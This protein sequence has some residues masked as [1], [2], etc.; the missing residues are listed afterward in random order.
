MKSVKPAPVNEMGVSELMHAAFRGD[1]AR[2]ESC[3]ARGDDPNFEVTIDNNK[4]N[5]LRAAAQG[6]HA[7]VIERLLKCGKLKDEIIDNAFLEAALRKK[8]TAVRVF[9]ENGFNPNKVVQ[10]LHLLGCTILSEDKRIID[11]AWQTIKTAQNL[12]DFSFSFVGEE[13][14]IQTTFLHFLVQAD[15]AMMRQYEEE[16][17]FPFYINIPNSK[18][19]TPL[20]VAI[21]AGADAEMVS[22]ILRVGGDPYLCNNS[23]FNA[24]HVACAAWN[25]EAL[26]GLEAN[27]PQNIDEVLSKGEP[28]INPFFAVFFEQIC[29]NEEELEQYQKVISYL[30]DKGADINQRA[31]DGS[32]ALQNIMDV[33]LEKVLKASQDGEPELWG[34][35]KMAEYLVERGASTADFFSKGSKYEK[36]LGEHEEFKKI[37]E[38]SAREKKVAA[39]K[40]DAEKKKS[41]KVAAAAASAA[42]PASVA[43]KEPQS[44]ILAALADLEEFQLDESARLESLRQTLADCVDELALGEVQ[45]TA[46]SEELGLVAQAQEAR[47]LRQNSR[48]EDL[49]KRE[50]NLAKYEQRLRAKSAELD[51]QQAELIEKQAMLE[52]L[53]AE[54]AREAE[55]RG[56]LRSEPIKSIRELPADL[57][58]LFA[59]LQEKEIAAFITGGMAWR[60]NRHVRPANDIDIKL[61]VPKSSAWTALEVKEFFAPFFPLEES[62]IV[63]YNKGGNFTISVKAWQG[64]LDITIND[65]EMP[66]PLSSTWAASREKMLR[67]NKAGEACYSY[68]EGLRQFLELNKIPPNYNILLLNPQAHKLLLRSCFMI[69]V[70]EAAPAEIQSA[71][72]SISA[73]VNP[74]ELLMKELKIDP[75]LGVEGYKSAQGK[76]KQEIIKTM[77]SHGFDAKEEK[78]FLYHF[79]ALAF[80]FGLEQEAAP[81]SK[82][83]SDRRQAVCAIDAILELCSERQIAQIPFITPNIGAII[84]EGKKLRGDGQGAALNPEAKAFASPQSPS[85]SAELNPEN[86]AARLVVALGAKTA[87]K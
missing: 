37:A 62:D 86:V 3:L 34:I 40:K 15:C 66:P 28:K 59:N 44:Q 51:R 33:I 12:E 65:P 7:G 58:N 43:E 5:A 49:K 80:Y 25:L 73:F 69:V 64:R 48:E 8:Q 17:P 81:E 60:C 82:F 75:T 84:D 36:V 57:Q 76:A 46:R 78:Q 29:Q 45:L 77:K 30:L 11:L 4:F 53:A 79:A 85:A 31:G 32:L 83:L 27:F 42:A 14:E 54:M 2:V 70:G 47:E 72:G 10:G 20:H 56:F 61:I 24:F 22:Y 74:L 9:L 55:A 21:L 50:E 52:R 87:L 38:I 63:I 71:L 68:P 41:R 39:R 16:I 35:Y 18:G 23:G 1:L 6:G 26:Q 67:F 19:L 13:G